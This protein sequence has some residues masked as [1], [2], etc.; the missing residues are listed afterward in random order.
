[1]HERHSG[2]GIA[3]SV[4][5]IVAGMFI[6]AVVV[7]AGVLAATTPGGMDKRSLPAMVLGL[8][9]I[10]MVV[11]DLVAMGLGIGGLCQSG[12]NKLF[13]ILGTVLSVVIAVGTGTMIVVG[14]LAK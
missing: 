5:S 2:L 14:I 1:M 7:A 9:I 13:A 6:L 12:R 3:S 8:L 4:I 10:L 11:I